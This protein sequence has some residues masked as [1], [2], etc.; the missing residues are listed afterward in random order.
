[1]APTKKKRKEK[2]KKKIVKQTTK[3]H[4]FASRNW[5]N[6]TISIFKQYYTYFYSHI[7]LTN[8]INVITVYHE[9]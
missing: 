9:F 7:F 6:S 3:P 8:T 1:M 4:S 5:I 2:K